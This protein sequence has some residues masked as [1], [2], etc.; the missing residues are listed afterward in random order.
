[1]KKFKKMLVALTAL[2]LVLCPILSNP[3]TAHAAEPATYQIRFVPSLNEY[4]YQ[5][6]TWGVDPHTYGLEILNQN[7][8]DGDYIV[9]EGDKPLTL[10]VTARV[11]N[12]TVVQSP[13]AVVTAKS[14]DNVYTLGTSTCAVN[15]DVTN[16]YV[17]D[18]SVVNFNN[19][20]T[21]M[22]IIRSSAT[23]GVANINALGTVGY[24]KTVQVDTTEFEY[25]NFQ[26]GSFKFENGKLTT[27][28]NKFQSIRPGVTTVP[29]APTTTPS[30]T[31]STSVGEYDAVP[32]TGDVRFNPM[33]LVGLAAVCLAGGYALKRKAN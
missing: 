4:R 3:I 26:L 10:E 27:D 18:G 33:W 17:Y 2:A 19:N 21:N 11:G 24:A 23:A 8:K 15:G 12:L 20:V 28:V 25:W 30:T 32:K 5:V 7:F 9:I 13:I 22:E 16:A 29:S 14:F 6:G 31:P 1:M